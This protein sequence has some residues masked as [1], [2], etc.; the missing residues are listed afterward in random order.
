[1]KKTLII[2]AVFVLAIIAT[3]F[4]YKSASA[5]DY[6][7][8]GAG[9]YGGFDYGSYGSS[10]DSYGSGGYGYGSGYDTYGSGYDAYGAGYDQYGCG[11]A[12]GDSYS[13]YDSYGCGSSCGGGFGGYSSGCGSFCGG[14]YYGGFGGFGIGY[15]Y[16]PPPVYIPPRYNPPIYIPPPVYVPPVYQPP[17]YVPPV[18]NPPTYNP[19][20]YTPPP[21][22]YPPPV[23]QPPLVCSIAFSNFN[24]PVVAVEGQLYSYNLQSYSTGS[25]SHQISYRLVNGPDGLIVLPN[26][27][28]AWTPAFN[29]GR[30]TSYTVTVAA[31]NGACENA[32]TFSIQVR[33]VN[34]LPPPVYH[35]KPVCAIVVPTCTPIK[36]LLPTYGVCPPDAPVAVATTNTI[37]TGSGFG[38]TAAISAAF[39]GLM[40]A[41]LSLLYSPWLLLAVIIILG[42]LL[43]RAYQRSRATQIAI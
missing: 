30:A 12:C 6:D 34:L 33:D 13:S 22:Y 26:G 31:Y 43:I 7:S 9:G 27:Q 17:V 21:V 15:N 1:M 8:Y 42:I 2:S 20:I 4:A 16:L 18:Y 19:P 10:Y 5:Q 24:P 36:P 38:M 41:L 35:P 37:G 32:Q 23:Y 29:Q 11:S 28:V 39:A 40:G 3:F 25:I 14:G